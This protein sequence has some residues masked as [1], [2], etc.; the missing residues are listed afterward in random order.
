MSAEEVIVIS[1]GGSLIVPDEIDTRFLSNFKALIAR[2]VESTSRRFFIITGGGKV[3]RRYQ[4]A[5]REVNPS[6][7]ATDVD[8]LGIRTTELNA[9]FVQAMFGTMA[10][11]RIILQKSDL[12]DEFEKSIVIGAGWE[13]GSSSDLDAVEV[14]D[15]VGARTVVNLSNISH[16]YDKD[17]RLFDDAQALQQ[18]VWKE[19]RSFI[20]DEWDPGLS[21]PFDPIASEMAERLGISV[22]I[23]GNDIENLENYFERGS[24]EGTRIHP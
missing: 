3:C 16:A 19:Y 15:A 24:F 18:V 23:M 21:T 13:P 5:L 22:L 20:P 9:Y 7:T 10:D 1:L 11:K 17:P 6:V 14:A 2:Q 12:E 4:A 8:W